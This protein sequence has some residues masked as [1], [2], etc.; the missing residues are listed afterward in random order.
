MPKGIQCAMNS[1]VPEHKRQEKGSN[2]RL[3]QESVGSGQ[4]AVCSA[5]ALILAKR[6]E[7]SLIYVNLSI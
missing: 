7:Q 6:A 5:H 4:E 2:D 1:K 3:V